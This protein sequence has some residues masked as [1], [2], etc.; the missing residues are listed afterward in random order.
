[1]L[2]VSGDLLDRNQTY[3]AVVLRDTFIHPGDV[4]QS[5]TLHALLHG[6]SP[7]GETGA[8]LAS[9]FAPLNAYLKEAGI[10]ASDVIGATVFSTGDRTTRLQ[11]F[12]HQ[13]EALPAVALDAPVQPFYDH[14]AYCAVNGTYHA[15]EYQDG[16]PPFLTSGGVIQTRG[17]DDT[18]VE[19]RR[20]QVPFV[21]TFPKGKMPAAGFPLYLY[22]HG[23]GGSSDQVVSRGPVLSLGGDP[24]YGEGPGYVVALR[25]YGAGCSAGSLNPERIGDLSAGG[26]I[27]YD[28]TRPYAMRD[29]FAQ[30]ILDQIEFLKV[31]LALHVDPSTCSG[32]DASASPDGQ[33]R[34]DPSRTVIAG[35][36][37]GSY[38]TGMLASL[39]DG[40]LAAVLSGA[41]GGWGEFALGPQDPP[42]AS[43]IELYLGMSGDEHLDLYHPV[44]SVFDLTVG[45]A[46]NV[47]YVR[48]ILTDP[49]EGRH[50]PH[51]LV[52]EGTFD[53]QT[54]ANLQRGLVAAIGVDMLGD[55]QS[56]DPYQELEDAIRIAGNKI[57]TTE[58]VRGNKTRPDGSPLTYAVVRYAKDPYKEGHYVPFQRDDAKHDY[59]CFVQTL[60]SDPAGV[61]SIIRGS[62]FNGPC[63]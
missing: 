2:P 18:L 47:H 59:G 11:N 36:S 5:A 16:T 4:A 44:I 55:S 26:Y 21:V 7:G 19:Q 53:L 62:T 48:R 30:M 60:L 27:A 46:D 29:N 24:V 49:P 56:T 57:L 23:T 39:H 38:L 35:H 42:L 40:W 34:F 9:M 50:I 33:I 31:L 32:V 61:P 45:E 58:P 14:P 8:K 17:D 15:P 25:G 54:T 1:M 63:P 43:I 13:A 41:G 51:V 3:A 12:V 37:L 10:D 22:V 20:D 52:I 6:R 28:F